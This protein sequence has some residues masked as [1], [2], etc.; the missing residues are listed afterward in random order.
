MITRSSHS[1]REEE[2]EDIQLGKIWTKPSRIS[3]IKRRPEKHELEVLREINALDP[4][5]SATLLCG[6]YP[7]KEVGLKTMAGYIVDDVVQERPGERLERYR[8]KIR[9]EWE[10]KESKRGIQNG[11]KECQ[12]EMALG[13]LIDNLNLG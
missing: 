3:E 13:C 1:R 11:T 10:Q 12:K 9:R 2:D 8:G 5:L 4:I 7:T 6:S